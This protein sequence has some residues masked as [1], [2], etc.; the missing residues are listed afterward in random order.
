MLE[1]RRASAGRCGARSDLEG[2]ALGVPRV[3][4]MYVRVDAAR[5]D[6]LALGVN[7][8]RSLG[9]AARL[10]DHCKLPVLDA[11]V[12]L[13]EAALYKYCSVDYCEV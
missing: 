10:R 4:V 2:L 5:Q 3:A 12:R 9:K 6:V 8:A 1:E 13:A 11:D 7:D